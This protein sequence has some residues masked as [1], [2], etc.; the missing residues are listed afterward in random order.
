MRSF[1]RLYCI[2]LRAVRSS[3]AHCGKRMDLISVMGVGRSGCDDRNSE[4]ESRRRA[5]K[6]DGFTPFLFLTYCRI[7]MRFLTVWIHQMHAPYP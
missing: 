7:N 3:N 4:K 1:F 6:L 5:C 2:F